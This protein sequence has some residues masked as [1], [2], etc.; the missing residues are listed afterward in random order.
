MH[1]HVLRCAH[2]HF[3]AYFMNFDVAMKS[4]VLECSIQMHSNVPFCT[5]MHFHVLIHVQHVMCLS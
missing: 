1:S 2:M 5:E 4:D 3:G